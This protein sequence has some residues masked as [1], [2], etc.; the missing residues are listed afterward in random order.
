MIFKSK[1][2]SKNRHFPDLILFVKDGLYCISINVQYCSYVIEVC[3]IV[4]VLRTQRTVVG[5]FTTL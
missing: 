4:C 1:F 2:K 3:A 5:T